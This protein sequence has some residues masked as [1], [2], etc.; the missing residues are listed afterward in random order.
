MKRILFWGVL[1]ASLML[2]QPSPASVAEEKAPTGWR[3][4]KGVKMLQL[5]ERPGGPTEPQVAILE[6]S[7]DQLRE[8]ESDP[9]GFYKKYEVFGGS[10]S[11]HDQGHFVIRLGKSSADESKYPAIV[12]PVHDYTTSSAYAG[13]EVKEIK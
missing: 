7:S 13:F 6:L 1:A 9:L 3:I 12:I 11:D 4:V 2:L 8:L 10:L 5:W